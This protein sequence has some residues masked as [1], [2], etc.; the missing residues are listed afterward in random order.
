MAQ[1]KGVEPEQVTIPD[2][3]F[4]VT[5]EPLYG[6]KGKCSS[7]IYNH[8]D[9]VS[10]VHDHVGG[11]PR[12]GITNDTPLTGIPGTE[13]YAGLN[14]LLLVSD[15]VVLGEAKTQMRHKNKQRRQALR[16]K[17]P[18]ISPWT[19]YQG[20]GGTLHPTDHAACPSHQNSMCATGR[21]LQY[22]AADLLQEWATFEC[23]TKTRH[24]VV[25]DQNVGGSRQGATLLSTLVR[26]DRAFCCR[27]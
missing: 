19:R 5:G 3:Q 18:L 17:Q 23:P 7:L 20:M 15:S 9:S 12:P 8:C 27:S 22:P 4:R 13:T 25:K 21:A 16:A 11:H 1:G 6:G 2:I 24:T 26:G 14:Q 10:T